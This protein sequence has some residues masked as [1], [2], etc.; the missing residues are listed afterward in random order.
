MK[1][2]V[3]ILGVLATLFMVM[4][5]CSSPSGGDPGTPPPPPSGPGTPTTYSGDGVNFD[6]VY[7]PGGVTFPTG[8]GDGTTAAVVAAYQIGETEVT[9]ELWYKVKTWAAGNG[10]TFYSTPGK[11]GSGTNGADPTAAK[12]EPVTD[13]TWFDAVVWC[14]ALT[15]WYNAKNSTNLTPVYYYDTDF[16]NDAK[17]ARNST[18]STNFVKE[19]SGYSY[20]SAYE[21][22]G[23]TGFRL[24]KS[25]EWEL[26]ARW[27]NDTTNVVSTAGS[28]PWFTKGDS[29]S[30]ATAAYSN[31]TATN[32]VAWYNTNSSSTTHPVGELAAN[33]LGIYD[34]SGNVFEWCFD[35]RPSYSGSYRFIRGGAWNYFDFYL[36]VG[37]VEYTGPTF[38]EDIL[39]FRL[40]RTAN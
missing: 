38:R 11:E 22:P 30:G 2:I 3:M 10:Y 6:L 18:Y 35:W 15:E 13:V 26:A 33:G 1:K 34:M 19:F 7:V 29:A 12:Q 32:A 8:T 4:F 31:A 23:A 25:D 9:Y 24:P 14:N 5:S 17:V 20:A 40:A 37:D 39:G 27:R 28:G 36:Q 21:K 16:D